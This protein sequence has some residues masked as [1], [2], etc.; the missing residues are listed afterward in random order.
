MFIMKE[1]GTKEMGFLEEGSAKAYAES[2]GLLIDNEVLFL[3]NEK[4]NKVIG[5]TNGRRDEMGTDIG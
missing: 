2:I 3:Y 5:G 1:D 4:T